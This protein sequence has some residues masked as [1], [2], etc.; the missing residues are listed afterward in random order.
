MTP[1]HT[2]QNHGIS[3]KTTSW[4]L[5]SSYQPLFV[6]AGCARPIQTSWATSPW[7]SFVQLLQLAIKECKNRHNDE[8][9]CKF[10]E[11][12]ERRNYDD[13]DGHDDEDNKDDD[14][15]DEDEDDEDN[16]TINC[17]QKLGRMTWEIETKTMT[18]MM[19]TTMTMTMTMMT[20]TVMAAMTIN[21]MTTKQQSTVGDNWG[22]RIGEKRRLGG[23]GWRYLDEYFL[24]LMGDEDVV[25]YD[26]DDGHD[27]DDDEEDNEDENDDDNAPI[28][29]WQKLGRRIWEKET[30]MMTM[31]M[32]KT[33]M[34]TTTMTTMTTMTLMA[35]T[36]MKTRTTKQQSTVGDNWGIWVGEK[37]TT[38]LGCETTEEGHG[39]G[40]LV[41]FFELH[42]NNSKCMI[43][44]PQSKSRTRTY[45]AW[46]L[47]VG[48]HYG[49][50]D[51]LMMRARSD[52]GLT[53]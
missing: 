50:H 29:C 32:T 35:T 4:T 43:P 33:T 39:G 18:M 7:P 36:T 48:L 27:D 53:V 16:A 19:M 10:D 30:T 41:E 2:T 37:A 13:D 17:W 51:E 24:H 9:F 5:M 21:T 22:S 31:T 38:S 28:N 8:F 1:P 40:D 23:V 14:D 12:W 3:D 46:V 42:K 20:M 15:G 25:H 49:R 45:S 26:D 6:T 11:W 44:P 47:G 52:D 34:T